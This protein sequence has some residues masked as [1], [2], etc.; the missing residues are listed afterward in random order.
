MISHPIHPYD[1]S[2]DDGGKH[3]L[4]GL[5]G[6][7][8]QPRVDPVHDANRRLLCTGRAVGDD[9][10]PYGPTCGEVAEAGDVLRGG[11]RRPATAQEFH[12]SA[13]AS[14]WRIGASPDGGIVAA[15]PACMRP[16][17][18]HQAN[19]AALRRMVQP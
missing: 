2:N 16:T 15:C 6:L 8:Y 18:E 19:L 9:G 3:A 4:G 17:A 5:C 10:V 13:R 14:G 12:N 7:C 11:Q 1:P